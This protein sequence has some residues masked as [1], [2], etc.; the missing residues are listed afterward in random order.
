MIDGIISSHKH[1]FEKAMEHFNHELSSVRTGR[2][3]PALLATVMV[4][5]YGSKVPIQQVALLCLMPKL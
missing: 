5:S 2:A 1:N 3:N 4:D